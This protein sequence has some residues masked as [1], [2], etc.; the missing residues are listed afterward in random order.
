MPETEFNLALMRIMDEQYL[1]T[2]FYG[3]RQ[4]TAH[5]QRCGYEVNGKRIRR[6]LRLIGLEAIYP[7]PNLSIADK[8]H[9]VYPYLL[10]DVAITSVNHVREYGYHR[11]T[12]GKGLYVPGGGNGPVQPLCAELGDVQQYGEQLLRGSTAAGVGQVWGATDFQHRSGQPVYLQQ[13]YRCAA[14]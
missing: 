2:P 14:G 1:K 3:V 12:D 10:R 4:M 6:L 13:L 5:L 8:M 11:Y 9:T 7:R